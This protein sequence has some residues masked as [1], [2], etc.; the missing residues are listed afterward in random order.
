MAETGKI[1]SRAIT[2]RILLENNEKE[3]RRLKKQLRI[4]FR[5][6]RIYKHDLR[7]ER[8]QKDS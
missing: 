8:K 1:R 4:C 6:K 3:I 2:T 5:L 7:I